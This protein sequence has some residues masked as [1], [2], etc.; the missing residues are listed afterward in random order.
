VVALNRAVAVG[1]ANGPD[2]GLTAL[3]ALVAE[4]LL[5]GYGYL[6]SAR[7]DFLRRLGRAEEARQAYE[8]ALLLT[9]NAIERDFLTA[10]LNGLEA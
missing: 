10:R 2:A 9:E 6:A 1:L 4:P 7:A 8:E 3:D 5:A